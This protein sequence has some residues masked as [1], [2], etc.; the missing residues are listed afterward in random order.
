MR[1]LFQKPPENPKNGF[2]VGE[3]ITKPHYCR[4]GHFVRTLDLSWV[5]SPQSPI[6]TSMIRLQWTDHQYSYEVSSHKGVVK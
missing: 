4:A 2:I 1:T 6:E 5:S 3:L